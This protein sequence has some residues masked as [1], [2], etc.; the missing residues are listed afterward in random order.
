MDH[1]LA[2]YRHFREV[3]FSANRGLFDQ[4]VQGQAPKAMVIACCDSRVDPG[5][6]FDAKPGE[7]FSLRN[8]ANLVPPYSPDDLYHGTSAAIEFAVRTLKVAHII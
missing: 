3:Y 7:I 8:V 4:L 2:G 6:I 5:L 1:L